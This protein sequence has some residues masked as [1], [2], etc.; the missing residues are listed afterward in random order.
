MEPIKSNVYLVVFLE[1][2]E[3][4]ISRTT[5]HKSTDWHGRVYGDWIESQ[6]NCD[7]VEYAARMKSTALVQT[8]LDFIIYTAEP[9]P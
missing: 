5:V 6:G 8:E 3:K 2:F 7:C 1:N 9:G 4:W